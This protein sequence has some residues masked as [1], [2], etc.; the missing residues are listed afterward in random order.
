MHIGHWLTETERDASLTVDLA[1]SKC[2]RN[3]IVQMQVCSFH[4]YLQIRFLQIKDPSQASQER[5][6][7]NISSIELI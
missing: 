3:A 5:V 7:G 4:D 2:I 6:L 1:D